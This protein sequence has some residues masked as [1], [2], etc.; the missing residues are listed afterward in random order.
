MKKKSTFAHHF[1]D[2]LKVIYITKRRK[3]VAIRLIVSHDF[4]ILKP[5][6]PPGKKTNG[7]EKNEP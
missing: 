2:K 3:A 7:P 1:L 5:T 6:L 4:A